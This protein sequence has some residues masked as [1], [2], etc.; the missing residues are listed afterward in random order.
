MVPIEIRKF[1]GCLSEEK[2]K[3]LIFTFLLRIPGKF[4]LSFLRWHK[5][6]IKTVLNKVIRGK[7]SYGK[8][9]GKFSKIHSTFNS[10][11]VFKI[12][13]LIVHEKMLLCLKQLHFYCILP[14][15][16]VVCMVHY[17]T[18]QLLFRSLSAFKLIRIWS[19]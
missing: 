15:F 14:N 3:S 9:L 5:W 1:Y 13:A 17:F 8:Q 11:K 16:K 7:D 2:G 6:N 12:L 10:G 18:L 4:I 19:S